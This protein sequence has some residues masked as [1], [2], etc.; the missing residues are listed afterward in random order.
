MRNPSSF[1]TLFREPAPLSPEAGF[2]LP[3]EI[4]EIIRQVFHA[5]QKTYS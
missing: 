4:L 1:L 3:W 2:I 5:V